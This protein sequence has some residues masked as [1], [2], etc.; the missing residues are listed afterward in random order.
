MTAPH[1]CGYLPGMIERKVFTHLIGRRAPQLNDLLTQ[2]GFRRSQTIAYRPACEGCRACVSVRVP[3]DLF[4]PSK[5]HKRIITANRDLVGEQKANASTGELYSL[6]RE[7]LSTRHPDGG[8]ME[9]SVLDFSL[10]IEDSHV[11]TD[12]IEYRRRGP[13]NHPPKLGSTLARPD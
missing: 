9:M 12:V 10:M 5:S 6:F 13:D 4:K 3:V 8:M 1:A 2:A 7:Y 11:E